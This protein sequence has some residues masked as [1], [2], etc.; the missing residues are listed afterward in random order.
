MK[1]SYNIT[2]IN[3]AELGLTE[4]EIKQAILEYIRA[5]NNYIPKGNLSSSDVELYSSSENENN[6]EYRAHIKIELSKDVESYENKP[7]ESGI[8]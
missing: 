8:S 2:K 3:R 4:Y 5:H 7:N 1:I 6:P